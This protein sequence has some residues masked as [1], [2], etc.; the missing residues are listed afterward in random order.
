M[1]NLILFI[2]ITILAKMYMFFHIV[3][4]F[5]NHPLVLFILILN[6]LILL[7]L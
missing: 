3:F 4:L 7:C 1:F 2:K 6:R 5:G